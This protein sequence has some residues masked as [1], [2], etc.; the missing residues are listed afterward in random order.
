MLTGKNLFCGDSEIEYLLEVLQRRGTPN[1]VDTSFYTKF[2]GLLKIG[3]ALPQFKPPPLEKTDVDSTLNSSGGPME[4]VKLKYGFEEL[5]DW[6][7]QIDPTK[8]PTAK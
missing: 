1:A 5:I 6:L 8:R 2:T 3:P 7:T 4:K